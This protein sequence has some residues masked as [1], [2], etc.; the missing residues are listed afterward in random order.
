MKAGDLTDGG[1]RTGASRAHWWLHPRFAVLYL[2]IPLLVAAY[3][4]PENSYLV[5]YRT[6]KYID[7]N[8]V[9]I[10]L[11]IYVAFIVGTFFL[12]RTGR[13]SQEREAIAYCRWVIWP[14]F[15]MAV[16]GYLAWFA[17]AASRAGGP[18]GLLHAL[19]DVLL[20]PNSGVSDNVKNNLFATVKG[21]TTFTQFGILYATVEALLWSYRSAPRK[22]ALMRFLPLLTFSLVRA[23]LIS[24]RLALMEFLV[25]V[26][27]VLLSRASRTRVNRILLGFFPLLGGLVV[28]GLFAFSEYFR[29]WNFYKSIYAGSYPQFAA[30]RFLGYYATA[31]N[32]AAVHYYYGN[33]VQP[34]A[35]TLDF[36]FKAPLVGS[37]ATSLY[38][39]FFPSYGMDGTSLLYAYANPEFNNVAPV[40]A[41]ISDF[42]LP[43]APVA[44]FLLGV[45]SFS[46]YKSFLR[47]R[48]VG[49]LLYPSWFVGLLEFSRIY[50]WPG[51]RYF[52]VL[53]FVFL[54]LILFRL[55]RAR[56]T[57]DAP[58]GT[59]RRRDHRPVIRG[60]PPGAGGLVGGKVET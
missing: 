47:G 56:G 48:L 55:A 18:G 32:N 5:L 43:F 9:L 22:T 51:G 20:H 7:P 25:P 44:A 39:S 52:P 15:F 46:L 45:V 36:L 34:L 26:G 41:L 57:A 16:F 33:G 50:Y 29:S 21:V 27:V 11:L 60:K 12:L 8:F 30:D 10:G 49:L 19:L 6:R 3:L 42:S 37:K 17:V 13:Q 24:E 54:S 35:N 38:G 59:S 14:L 28:F 4:I 58:V 40:F 2:G 1:R 31:L 23:L 53:A